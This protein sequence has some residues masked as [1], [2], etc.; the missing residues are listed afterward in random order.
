[1]MVCTLCVIFYMGYSLV[2][3]KGCIPVSYGLIKDEYD[4]LKSAAEK[5]LDECDIVLV[6]GGSSVGKKDNTVKV[7][8]DLEDGKLF[9][10]S[11]LNDSEQE[12]LINDL[13]K[14][15]PSN[16]KKVWAAEFKAN[17]YAAFQNVDIDEKRI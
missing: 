14:A 4:L 16:R 11:A 17:M 10:K 7:I 12:Y 9:F 6:S 15:W 2:E 8:E 1:M 13:K 3:D 5:A